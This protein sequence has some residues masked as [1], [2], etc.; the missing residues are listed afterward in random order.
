MVFNINRSLLQVRQFLNKFHLPQVVIVNSKE[1]ELSLQLTF[2]DF[3]DIFTIS[4]IEDMSVTFF[5]PKAGPVWI[6]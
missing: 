6:D 1:L 2:F 3:E 5:P 4:F